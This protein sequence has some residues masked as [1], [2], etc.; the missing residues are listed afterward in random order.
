MK[1]L[2]RREFLGAVG[3]SAASAATQQS[4]RQRPNIL[5][6]CSDNFNPNVVGCAGHPIVK[7]PNIDRLAA[8]GTYFT[9][10]YCGSPVCAPSRAGLITGMFPS[11]VES[12]CNATPFQGPAPTWGQRLRQAG[13][14]CKATGK[15]DLTARTDLGF[16]QVLT[17]HGHEAHPDVTALFRRPLCYRVDERP[18]IDGRILEGEHTDVPVMRTALGFLRDNAPKRPEPWA[19]YVG[20]VGPL[21]GFHAERRYYEM[22]SPANVDLPHIP[23]GY[24]ETLPEPWQATRSFK[25]IATP[26]PE[27]R[28]RRARAAYYGNVTAVDERIGQLLDQLDRSGLREN[29]VVVYTADHG[30]SLGEHGLWYHNE[31]TDNSS[32]VTL[33]VAGPG[34]LAGRRIHTPVM[35]ADLYPT[36][37]ELAGA[38]VPS[39]LRGHS[40]LPMCRGQAGDHPGFAYG[41]C[42]AEGTCTGSF[43]IRKGSWKYIHYT[44]YDSLLFNMEQDPMEMRNVVGTPEGRQV[45]RELRQILLSLVDPTERTER[46]FARQEQILR[47]LCARLTFEELLK[48]GFERRLG[49]GQAVTL[50]KKH[51]R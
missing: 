10:C 5:F 1:E 50:L 15:M 7:T 28:I 44:Y 23:P 12:F 3:A 2:N 48:F 21:P 34:I 42:H 41:E 29:T 45:S 43:V 14:Y 46:A 40:L 35:H 11:D 22:Y 49:K 24:L 13:Y 51:K 25:R 26:I 9:N 36:L 4:S 16:E 19:L 37:L 8:E 38:T 18:D 30:R 6:I 47:D 32:R 39:G 20:Y 17:T 31:P 33:I 27:R